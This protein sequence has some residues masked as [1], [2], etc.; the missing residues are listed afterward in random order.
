MMNKREE[1]YAELR[2]R[3]ARQMAREKLWEEEMDERRLKEKEDKNELGFS[4]K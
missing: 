2:D 4:I 1:Y 3:K